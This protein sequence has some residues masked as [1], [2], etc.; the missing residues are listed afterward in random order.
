MRNSNCHSKTPA[1]SGRGF[2]LVEMLTVV[3]IITLLVALTA[4][5]LV[6]VIRSTRLSSAGDSLITRIS[7]AQQSAV[8]LS[9]EVELRFYKYIDSNSERPD[10]KAFYAYQVVHDPGNQK[11]PRALSEPYYLESGIVIADDQELSPLCRDDNLTPQTEVG[12]SEGTDERFLFTPNADARPNE[13]EYTALR[14][15]PDGSCRSLSGGDEEEEE[16]VPGPAAYVVPALQQSFLT[17]VESRFADSSNPTNF[18]CIQIDPYTG[19][20]RVYRP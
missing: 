18:Y 9:S 3:G 5:T 13:V 17:L 6:D 20:T 15:Y 14:F 12:T 11:P 2:T 19:K 16:G 1:R 4:P 10:R 7:L 8:S